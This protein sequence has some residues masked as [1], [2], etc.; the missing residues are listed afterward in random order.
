MAIDKRTDVKED[1]VRPLREAATSGTDLLGYIIELT[2]NVSKMI[3]IIFTP[4]IL[5]YMI[6]DLGIY[7]H[8]F[9]LI[10][11]FL[12]KGIDKS[13]YS[14]SIVLVS[15]AI[16]LCYWLYKSALFANTHESIP[17]ILQ[18][19]FGSL[20]ISVLLI[21]DFFRG[22]L[23]YKTNLG[24]T[25]EVFY[26]IKLLVLTFVLSDLILGS[27]AGYR[28]YKSGKESVEEPE[29][30]AEPEVDTEEQEDDE[31]EYGVDTEEDDDEYFEDDEG[32]PSSKT[33]IF[34]YSI[35]FISIV[36]AGVVFVLKGA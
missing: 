4:M 11:R 35:F 7:H 32:K 17:K 5:V 3:G 25:E 10:G 26:A 2:I 19:S 9:N 12:Y 22:Y 18:D 33:K 29:N 6:C 31:A 23:P 8:I 14:L 15:L 16:P 36:C 1:L 13:V 34:A 28:F 20:L 21:F 24:L 30:E 27:I